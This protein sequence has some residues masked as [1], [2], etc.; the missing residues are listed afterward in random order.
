MTKRRPRDAT[1]ARRRPLCTPAGQSIPG[2][3]HAPGARRSSTRLMG[4]VGSTP[5]LLLIHDNRR[6]CRDPAGGHTARPASH[7]RRPLFAYRRPTPA[8]FAYRRPMITT[9]SP[10]MSRPAISKDAE[11]EFKRGAGL[12]GEDHEAL[13]GS[14]GA[15]PGV[16]GE[17]EVADGLVPVV[18]GAVAARGLGA[19]SAREAT[20]P[21]GPSRPCSTRPPSRARG[22]P[23]AMSRALR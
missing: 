19:T 17:G 10:E 9:G 7:A 4:I 8:T 14:V 2:C 16:A 3:L 6:T 22:P 13:A 5:G 1:A 20:A 23:A 11:E 21:T 12:G 15:L 18:F